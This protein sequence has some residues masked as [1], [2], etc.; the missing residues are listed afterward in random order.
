M[1]VVLLWLLVLWGVGDAET[2]RRVA[3]RRCWWWWW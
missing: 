3:R 1:V 2:E